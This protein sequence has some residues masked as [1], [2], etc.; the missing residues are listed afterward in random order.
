MLMK[1][2]A[3]G[4]VNMGIG[5]KLSAVGVLVVVIA[6]WAVRKQREA[7]DSCEPLTSI[8]RK[9][10]DLTIVAEEIEVESKR[11]TI[12][13]AFN[14]KLSDFTRNSEEYSHVS[15]NARCF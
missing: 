12:G 8:S 7:I 10:G 15:R 14:E 1:E 13:E 2:M 11:A 6:F 3:I 9:L 4:T 5:T